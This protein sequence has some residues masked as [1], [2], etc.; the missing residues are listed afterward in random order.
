MIVHPISLLLM[1]RSTTVTLIKRMVKMMT[2]IKMTSLVYL[3]I[4]LTTRQ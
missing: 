4:T 1:R 2:T 3:S